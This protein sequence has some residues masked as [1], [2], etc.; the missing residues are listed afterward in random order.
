MY[1]RFNLQRTQLGLLNYLLAQQPGA[2]K[3]HS[4]GIVVETFLL[5]PE[6]MFE[7]FM[8]QTVDSGYEET[9][10]LIPDGGEVESTMG[11]SERVVSKVLGLVYDLPYGWYFWEKE[12]QDDE[13][14]EQRVQEDRER[15]ALKEKATKCLKNAIRSSCLVAYMRK[16]YGDDPCAQSQSSDTLFTIGTFKAKVPR[17]VSLLN[18]DWIQ[19]KHNRLNEGGNASQMSATEYSQS[20]CESF[21][22]RSPKSPAPTS[23]TPFSTA[24]RSLF[25]STGSG[26]LLSSQSLLSMS[27]QPLSNT[28]MSSATLRTQSQ[29]SQ[30]NTGATAKPKKKRKMGF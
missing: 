14:V 19:D 23:P 8:D 21:S 16:D 29:S 12:P 10:S 1:D 24:P 7:Y 18:R 13:E 11:V 6:R 20:E 28:I 27:S 3:R 26:T 25:P 9:F 15:E 30:M 22:A 4:T 2:T 5:G 17:I